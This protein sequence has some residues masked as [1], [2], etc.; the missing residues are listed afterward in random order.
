MLIDA[1]ARDDTSPRFD[2]E[3]HSTEETQAIQQQAAS[4]ANTLI[5][6]G[7]QGGTT[8]KYAIEKAARYIAEQFILGMVDTTNQAALTSQF[9]DWQIDFFTRIK[10]LHAQIVRAQAKIPT[11]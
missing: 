1:A 3:D 10:A 6:L 9:A 4:M 7:K 8:Y 5:K 11:K 2:A